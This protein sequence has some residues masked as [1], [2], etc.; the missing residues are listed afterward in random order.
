LLRARLA[1]N[2]TTSSIIPRCHQRST[3]ASG[4]SRTRWPTSSAIRAG[5]RSTAT[6]ASLS[7]TTSNAKPAEPSSAARKAAASSNVEITIDIEPSDD[8]PEASFYDPETNSWQEPHPNFAKQVH[9]LEQV[10]DGDWAWCDVTVTARFSD[11]TGTAYLSQRS[12]KDEA[13]FKSDGD[14]SQMVDEA[15][16]ELQQHIDIVYAAIHIAAN[17]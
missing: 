14:Y 4:S 5:C 12:Y 10:S 2:S 9:E 16:H 1:T 11:L 3:T 6:T 13:D 17:P 8:P 15:I 7:S